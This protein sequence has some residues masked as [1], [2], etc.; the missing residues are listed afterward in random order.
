MDAWQVVWSII[1]T[2]IAVAY[3]LLNVK[4]C[5][6]D[7]VFWKSTLSSSLLGVVAFVMCIFIWS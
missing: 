3:L 6:V 4:F 5:N 7:D 1:M 2:C